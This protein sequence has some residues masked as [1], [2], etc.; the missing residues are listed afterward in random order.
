VLSVILSEGNYYKNVNDI[1]IG[2]QWVHTSKH[3]RISTIIWISIQESFSWIRFAYTP[4]ALLTLR[5]ARWHHHD[6]F[7]DV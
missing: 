1:I 5:L 6:T 3:D 2:K 4:R 7:K